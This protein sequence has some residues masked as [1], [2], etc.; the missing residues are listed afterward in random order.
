MENYG[1]DTARLFMMFAAPPEQ[2]LE[3]SDAGVEGAFRFLK[4]LWKVTNEH[5]A[6][7]LAPAYSGG[8]LSAGLKDLRFKLHATIQ[9]V[10]DDYGRRQ[11]FN[12]AIAAV[13]ELLN[14]YDKTDKSGDAGRA[15]RRKRWKPSCCCCLPSCRISATRCG[16]RCARAANCCNRPGRK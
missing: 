15:V 4:R 8:E 9:K 10:A 2:S 1:A 3:W 16:T 13:M 11:Q 6:A 12:T 5:V 14:T 7:G